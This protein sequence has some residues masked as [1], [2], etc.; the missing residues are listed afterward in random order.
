MKVNQEIRDI[1]EAIKAA[2]PVE[3]IYLFG[4]H[5]Y[6]TPNDDSD[7]DFFVVIPDDS[8]RPI[9]AMKLARRSLRTVDRKT[10]TDILADYS[11]RFDDRKQ[12]NTLEKKIVNEGMVLYERQN[13][14]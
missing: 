3:R 6:G 10:P 14:R 2:V 11:S 13:A 9:D 7:Y 12:Y 4:S 5:A 8:M 1:T